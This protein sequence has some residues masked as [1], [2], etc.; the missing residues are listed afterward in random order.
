MRDLLSSLLL[1]EEI[2]LRHHADHVALV[3]DDR[4]PL[5]RRSTNSCATSF[6]AVVGSTVMTC[7]RIT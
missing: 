7:G 3:V 2:R 1:D 4:T 5:I 6:N